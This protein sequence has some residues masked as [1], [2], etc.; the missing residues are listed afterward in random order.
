MYGEVSPMF[1][2]KFKFHFTMGPKEIIDWAKTEMSALVVILDYRLKSIEEKSIAS[3]QRF[4]D[5]I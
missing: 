2:S 4:T 3:T 1:P 5:K